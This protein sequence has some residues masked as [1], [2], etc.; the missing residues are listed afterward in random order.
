MNLSINEARRLLE[1]PRR[2]PGTPEAGNY[3]AGCEKPG[4]ALSNRDGLSVDRGFS[5]A[6]K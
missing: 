2:W 1:K 5:E 6:T 4:L 3:F